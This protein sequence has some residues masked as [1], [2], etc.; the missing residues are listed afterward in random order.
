MKQDGSQGTKWFWLWTTQAD[1]CRQ[2]ETALCGPAHP[3][4]SGHQHLQQPGQKG[5]PQVWG[6]L[7]LQTW[8]SS[9][10]SRWS[11]MEAWWCSAQKSQTGGSCIF[12]GCLHQGWQQ[13]RQEICL[14]GPSQWCPGGPLP[15]QGQCWKSQSGE[16]FPEQD[17]HC[18]KN[19]S[20]EV[21]Q[22][23]DLH[24]WENQSLEVFPEEDLQRW[25][26][27]SPHI[28]PGRYKDLQGWKIQSPQVFPE[29]DLHQRFGQ[30]PN[31]R[32]GHHTESHQSSY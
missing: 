19:P 22:K 23:Q 28:F 11:K 25:K 12:P 20:P 27:Q 30:R 7:H 21:F 10:C 6:R 1:R 24:C 3:T 26:N 9:A 16:I 29:Q 13:G 14:E 32:Q 8:S 15:A 31:P 2:V 18:W 5:G 17:L 4:K